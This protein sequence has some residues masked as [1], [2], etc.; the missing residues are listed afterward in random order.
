MEVIFSLIIGLILIG[1]SVWRIRFQSRSTDE[2]TDATLARYVELLKEV[3]AQSEYEREL[4]ENSKSK[5][6]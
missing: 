1:L 2:E 6:D 4:S 3:S 5:D